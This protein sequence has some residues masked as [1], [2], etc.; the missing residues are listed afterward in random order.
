[1]IGYLYPRLLRKHKA[2]GKSRAKLFTVW[3]VYKRRQC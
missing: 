2:V 3:T 1:M